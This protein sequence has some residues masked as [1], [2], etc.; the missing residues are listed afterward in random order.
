MK[1]IFRFLACVTLFQALPACQSRSF[2]KSPAK[3]ESNAT[4]SLKPQCQAG[5]SL[6]SYA[7][8][9]PELCYATGRS[10][11]DDN[12]TSF[13]QNYH[14]FPWIPCNDVRL[15]SMAKSKFETDPGKGFTAQNKHYYD[16]ESAKE[17]LRGHKVDM[18]DLTKR[19]FADPSKPFDSAR[20]V[21]ND[22]GTLS[23]P[24]NPVFNSPIH[25][26]MVEV[27]RS[28]QDRL[29]INFMLFGGT[30]G[31][32]IL[33][34]TLVRI[35]AE[36][37]SGRNLKVIFMHDFDNV[38][39]FE[40]EMKP[41][42]DE[43]IE[44]SLSGKY[45]E[46]LLVMSSDIT[47]R[48][49]SALP[50][51]IQSVTAPLQAFF[52][53][54]L[55]LTGTSDHTKIIVADPFTDNANMIVQSKNISDYN[56][57]NF[58][59]GAVIKGP[60]ASL[61]MASYS[62]DI[63][64]AFE[65]NTKRDDRLRGKTNVA[66]EWL[67]SIKRGID[68]SSP[69][70]YKGQGNAEVM[71]V[72]N[73]ADDSVRNVEHAMLKMISSA[74]KNVRVYN[75]LAYHSMVAKAFADATKRLPPQNVKMILDATLTYPLNIL[76]QSMLRQEMAFDPTNPKR[77]LDHNDRA[78][79]DVSKN[80]RWRKF[81]SP[82]YQKKDGFID[83]EPQ[84]HTKTIVV[85]D[86]YTFLGSANF[87]LNTLKGAFREFS[88]IIKD[89]KVARE[90]GQIFDSTWKNPEETVDSTEIVELK[91]KPEMGGKN[92]P[93]DALLNDL[94]VGA[95]FESKRNFTIN[96][97]NFKRQG[98]DNRKPLEASCF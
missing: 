96:P 70:R 39:V 11:E 75:M 30:W 58:D 29:Y 19:V 72:E 89:E 14:L 78:S 60:A 98:G 92:P 12:L 81:L 6:A 10:G 67:D 15:V 87:D 91:K 56:H 71:L 17:Y 66:K 7:Q 51:G 13:K 53:S 86:L 82:I 74:Q 1:G 54:P 46:N 94:I 79:V 37:A 24:Q 59:E 90:A 69:K 18:A 48:E 40:S 44:Q 95:Q 41:L 38:F 27:I 52:K 33:R 22:Q 97:R 84:Q 85:D 5:I 20:T 80:I 64:L 45:A 16:F 55:S 42:W 4:A 25:Q 73:N 31:A 93:A 62:K 35:D 68:P 32:E 28:A 50:I 61:A 47:K 8:R 21:T 76:F 9:K 2:E 26:A 49:T 57:T 23:F 34:E 83:V 88:V 36:K 43:M 3:S 63:E 77:Q 65:K